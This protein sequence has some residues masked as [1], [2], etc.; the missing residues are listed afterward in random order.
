VAYGGARGGGK[1]HWALAQLGA[2]DCQRQPGL[3][4]LLL[5]KVAKA[6]IEHFEDLRKRLFGRLKH[7]FSPHRGILTFGNDSRIIAGHFKDEKDIDNYL[8]LEYDAIVIEEATTLSH[9]KRRD[10]ETCLRTSKP[11]WR[12]RIYE[13]SN[14]GGVGHAWFKARYIA[15]FVASAETSTRFIPARATDNSF[16]NPEYVKVLEGLTGWQKRAWCDGD[17]DIAAGQYFT[18]FRREVHVLGQIDDTL[19]REWALALDYGFTHFTACYLGFKDGDGNLFVVDEHAERQW[20]PERHALA[21]KAMLGRHQVRHGQGLRPLRL[22]DLSRCVAGADVFSKQSDGS[23]VA[24]AYAKCGIKFMCANTDRV[25]GWAEI[26]RRFGDTSAGIRPSLF[27]HQRCARLIESIPNLQHDPNR[28]E[29]V[30]KVDCDEDGLGGD[31]FAD[32]F[33]Y[34]VQSKGRQVTSRKLRGL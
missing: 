16:N 21:I 29:D 14:P 2:D 20:L 27:I 1:S 24:Q 22:E 19:A 7:D 11:N 33:R 15:P 8:G 26:L 3:K 4:T 13:T 6:N 34:L 9:K 31:D 17:W 12:P 32:A 23:T 10:I 18:N 5:R 25:N 30:L 28:P